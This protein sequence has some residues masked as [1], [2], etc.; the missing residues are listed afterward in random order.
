MKINY[1]SLFILPLFLLGAGVQAQTSSAVQTGPVIRNNIPGRTCGTPI[2]PQQFETWLESLQT[3]TSGPKGGSNNSIESVFNIPVIV[4]VVHTGQSIGTGYNISQ[5]QVVDQI[6]ILNKD[7][8]GVNAD[9]SLIPAV[10]KPFLGK[11]K[12][13]FCLAV[14]SPSNTVLAEPGIERINAVSKGWTTGN[15]SMTYIDATIKPQSIWDPNRYFNIWVLDLGQ[16]LLG[17]ATIPNPVTTG[18]GGLGPPYGSATSDGI[19]C[20]NTAFG[21]IGSAAPPYNKGR[22]ATHESGH[23]LGL[24][25]TWGDATCA[26]DYCND[27]PTSNQANFGCPAFPHVTCSNGPNGDMFMDYMDYVDDACMQMFTK[28]QVVRMQLILANSPFRA[29]LL[30]STVCN[31]NSVT[32]DISVANI[33]NPT[34]SQTINCNLDV[35]PTI[36]MHNFGNNVVSAVIFT[37]NIDGVGT[38]TLNWAGSLAA[39]TSTT[40]TFPQMITTNGSHYFAVK[41][42]S[43]NAGTDSNLGNNYSFQPFTIT[44]GYTIAAN[45]ATTIC[46]GNQ[47]TITAT[48]G[49]TS[50]TWQPGSVV[51]STDAV[52]PAATTIYTVSGTYSNCVKTATVQVTVN[53]TPTLTANSTTICAGGTATLV[54]SGAATYS[55]STTQT[56]S[57]I[58]VNPASNTVYTIQGFNGPCSSQKQVSVAIGSSLGIVATA[59]PNGFC[60]GATATMMASG[61]SSYTWQPG[62]LTGSVVVVNPIT[63]QVYNITGTTTGCSGTGAITVTVNTTPTISA[64]PSSASV[65]IPGSGTNLTASGAA[66]YTWQPGNLVGSNV[67]I[68]PGSTTVYTCVGSSAAGCTDTKTTMV[69]VNNKPTINVGTSNPTICVGAVA[70]LFSTGANSY[71]W[72]PGSLA[73]SSPTVSP[74]STIT[75]TCTG[76]TNGCSDIQ[77]VAIQVFPCTSL[78][79]QVSNLTL[80]IYPNPAKDEL[81]FKSN[82]DI[83][84]IMYNA[85]GQMVKQENISREGKISIS[86]IPSAV[87]FVHV[88]GNNETKIVK[89]VKQ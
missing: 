39:A 68:N 30:T 25:H 87:Y 21:S 80:S 29:S 64:A 86:D 73:G 69:T 8:N 28:D 66:T 59:N 14:L 35:T 37:Y 18:L 48:G 53:L 81:F 32:N 7:Y 78:A 13:N 60:S 47:T 31:L 71:V 5:A 82:S 16:S 65:C 75:Y 51:S 58:T 49:A 1:K 54:A 72:Q 43:V 57:S 74:P 88:K 40:V 50:W 41:A 23:W 84:V 77:T 44:N 61:A 56:T 26:N 24:R 62:N 4:H 83:K 33:S 12:I 63:T 3:T 10:Y 55:W 11:A 52:T 2:L 6:N 67:A 42:V 85:L 9:T 89:V 22:T 36:L 76:T 27:T 45:G 79:T 34:Y 17:Y 70:S 46:S 19:V 15:Y 38:Q 20:L